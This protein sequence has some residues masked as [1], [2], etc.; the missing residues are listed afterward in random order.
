MEEAEYIVEIIEHK[1]KTIV[2]KYIEKQMEEGNFESVEVISVDCSDTSRWTM[3]VRFTPH[4]F[5][6]EINIER[7][8]GSELSDFEQLPE[9]EPPEIKEIPKRKWW[10]FWKY[11][12]R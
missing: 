6:I 10:Q 2:D 12:R 9:I 3:D 1:L 4:P 8:L 7:P 5:I 11:F